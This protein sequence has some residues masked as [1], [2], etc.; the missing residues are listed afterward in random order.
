MDIFTL[1][2]FAESIR[3][4][5][6]IGFE[7]R[8]ESFTECSTQQYRSIAGQGYDPSRGWYVVTRGRFEEANNP[9]AEA[10]L[11]DDSE[12]QMLL[13]AAAW[14]HKVTDESGQTF[15][16]FQERLSYLKSRLPPVLFGSGEKKTTPRLHLVRDT[17]E[18][19]P[20]DASH[21]TA[22][23]NVIPMGRDRE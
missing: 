3:V 22:S 8:P 23:P 18:T 4:I 5:H 17:S 21:D 13:A 6:E 7:P 1:L 12:R 15:L 14:I 19:G 10:R 9:P 16:S 2:K 20:R 11:V